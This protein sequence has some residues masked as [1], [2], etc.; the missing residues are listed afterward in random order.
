MNTLDARSALLLSAGLAA[1]ASL[2]TLTLEHNPLLDAGGAALAATL[3]SNQLT[4][5]SLAFTGVADG[6]CTALAAA[7][8]QGCKLATLNLSGCCCGPRGLVALAAALGAT[9]SPA[10][11]IPKAE[12]KKI[13]KQVAVSRKQGLEV[14]TDED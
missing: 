13:K 10:V 8:T 7:L 9:L 1:H 2:T 14:Y 3:P 12:L 4:T 6:T 11:K 5:L